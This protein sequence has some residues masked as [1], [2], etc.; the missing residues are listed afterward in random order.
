MSHEPLRFGL[1]DLPLGF[2]LSDLR[3]APGPAP[4]E[5][6]MAKMSAELERL[7]SIVSDLA[8]QNYPGDNET[9]DCVLCGAEFDWSPGL[10]NRISH[11]PGCPWLRATQEQ[12]THDN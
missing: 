8:A 2:D 11:D 4:F 6:K 10:A 7:R 12:S 3:E 1:E 9:G 5:H